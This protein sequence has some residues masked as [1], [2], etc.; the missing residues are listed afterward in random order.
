MLTASTAQVEIL[1]TILC[2]SNE[3]ICFA[4]CG[5]LLSLLICRLSKIL[6]NFLISN[7]LV[8]VCCNLVFYIF[9]CFCRLDYEY[10][11]KGYVFRKGRLK[12]TVSKILKVLILSIV[13]VVKNALNFSLKPYRMLK[14]ALVMRNVS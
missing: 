12:V 13:L 8:P 6:N 3:L 7:W 1:D 9:A 10:V 11:V 5:A 4:V 14:L 2:K